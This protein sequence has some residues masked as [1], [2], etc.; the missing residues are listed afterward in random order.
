MFKSAPSNRH[1]SK[2]V[3]DPHNN[4]NLTKFKKKLVEKSLLQLQ[5]LKMAQAHCSWNRVN[6]QLWAAI[7]LV[8]SYFFQYTYDVG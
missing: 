4:S 8:Y 6:G 3:D 1:K 2:N 7:V 5:S